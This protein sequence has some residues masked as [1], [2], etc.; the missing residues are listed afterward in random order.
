M[1][2]RRTAAALVLALALTGLL[3]AAAQAAPAPAGPTPPRWAG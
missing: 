3:P 1:I 2:R